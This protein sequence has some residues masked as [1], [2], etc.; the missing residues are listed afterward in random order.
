M[1]LDA[2]H[3]VPIRMVTALRC[4]WT[5]FETK[6]PRWKPGFRST[7]DQTTTHMSHKE[8]RRVRI[9]DPDPPH[10]LCHVRCRKYPYGSRLCIGHH[11]LTE[12]L[13]TEEFVPWQNFMHESS[14]QLQDLHYPNSSAV[15]SRG[16]QRQS[17]LEH[18]KPSLGFEWPWK[19][20]FSAP[21]PTAFRSN[22]KLL[23]RG[24]EKLLSVKG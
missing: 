23:K 1:P 16:V 21:Q 24:P 8:K 9:L 2:A 5:R 10:Y 18:L 17:I 11:N 3:M 7:R 12:N 13:L 6:T 14:E 20:T 19:A 15:C 22:K 4:Y